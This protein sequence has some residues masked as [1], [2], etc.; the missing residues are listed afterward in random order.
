MTEVIVT[1]SLSMRSSWRKT[2]DDRLD[3][4]EL[5]SKSKMAASAVKCPKTV[6]LA[7]DRTCSLCGG[8]WLSRLRYRMFSDSKLDDSS[9]H[10]GFEKVSEQDKAEKGS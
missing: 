9:T 1:S 7:I 5:K 2:N 4:W 8:S 6:V 3:L 10:F